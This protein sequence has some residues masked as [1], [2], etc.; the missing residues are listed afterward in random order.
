[1]ILNSGQKEVSYFKLY[2]E[3]NGIDIMNFGKVSADN[4]FSVWLPIYIALQFK[5]RVQR[6]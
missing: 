6:E 5:G 4:F 2:R 1:M 3:G